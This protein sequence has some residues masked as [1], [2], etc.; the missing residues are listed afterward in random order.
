MRLPQMTTRRWMIV[1]AICAIA[2]VAYRI[3][4]LILWDARKKQADDR[5]LTNH[6]HWEEDF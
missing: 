5:W 1:V 4:A 2:L 3:I 6:W